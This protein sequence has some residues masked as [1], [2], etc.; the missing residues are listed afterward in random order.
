MDLEC[1]VS[2]QKYKKIKRKKIEKTFSR[3]EK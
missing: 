3:I 2:R 1:H